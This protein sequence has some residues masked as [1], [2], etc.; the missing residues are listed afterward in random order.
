MNHNTIVSSP[1]LKSTSLKIALILVISMIKGLDQG[2]VRKGRGKWGQSSWG[3]WER[4][5]AEFWPRSWLWAELQLQDT[6]EGCLAS[7][8]RGHPSWC[9]LSALFQCVCA[10]ASRRPTVGFWRNLERE[11]QHSQ[12]LK[13]QGRGRKSRN[14]KAGETLREH[15]MLIILAFLF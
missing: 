4:L 8:W 13:S 6:W 10:I 3:S 11:V 7:L 12:W 14:K 1:I 15:W 5:S 2:F 9:Y